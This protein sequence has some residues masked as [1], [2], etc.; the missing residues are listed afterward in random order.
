MPAIRTTAAAAKLGIAPSTLRTWERRYGFPAPVRSAG[1]HRQYAVHEVEALAEAFARTGEVRAAIALAREPASSS[2]PPRAVATLRSAL[3]ALDEG[4]ADDV[5]ATALAAHRVESVVQ[6]VLLRVLEELP[7]GSPEHGLGLR[8]AVG[9]LAAQRRLAPPAT[10]AEGVLLLDCAA[11]VRAALDAVH[12]AALE[13][14]LRRAGLRVLALGTGLD[15]ARLGR[16]VR[17]LDPGVAVLAGAGA[18]LD[19]VGRLVFA[20]RRAG[21]DRVVVCAFRD[22]LGRASGSTV[23]RLAATP[24]GARDDVLSLVSAGTVASAIGVSVAG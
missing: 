21:G 19:A 15:P 9:W 4:A 17:A 8:W 7:P 18:D 5:L 3:E 1:G 12:L 11:G 16:A 24:V 13:L 14:A 2:R 20:T 23:P 6:D 22:A 10:R